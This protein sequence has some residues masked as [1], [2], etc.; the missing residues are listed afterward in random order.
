M[1]LLI[2]VVGLIASIAYFG[3]IPGSSP[4]KL[5]ET[6]LNLRVA[7][8]D[9]TRYKGKYSSNVGVAI[10]QIRS[11][12]FIESEFSRYTATGAYHILRISVINKQPNPILLDF[13]TFRL[14][15]ENNNEF[16]PSFVGESMSAMK[17]RRVFV[18]KLNP[19]MKFSGLIAYDV[20]MGA[21]ITKLSFTGGV[22]GE[23]KELPFQVIVE[24]EAGS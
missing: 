12:P 2:A 11:V 6:E 3:K 13:N 20:P 18:R 7:G 16:A 24:R 9:G 17:S 10:T 5:G 8:N 15:D 1:L 19:D 4:P 22:L 21:K 14:V 23:R